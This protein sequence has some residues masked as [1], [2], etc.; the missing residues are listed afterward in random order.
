MHEPKKKFDN[1]NLIQQSKKNFNN[2]LLVQAFICVS[3][4]EFAHGHRQNRKTLCFFLAERKENL[5]LKGR[6]R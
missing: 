6:I 5:I 1:N 4:K 3:K 2:F